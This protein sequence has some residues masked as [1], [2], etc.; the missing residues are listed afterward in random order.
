MTVRIKFWALLLAPL[1]F[2]G[3]FAAV[4]LWK[5]PEI[6]IDPYMQ[7]NVRAFYFA[8][9]ILAC[10]AYAVVWAFIDAAF[11]RP[12]KALLHG[13]R[14]ISRSNPAHELMMPRNH[15]LGEVPVIVQE[16]GASLHQA[17]KEIAAATATGTREIEAQKSRLEV[18]LRE[19]SEGVLVCD[20]DARV[21]LCNPAARRLLPTPEALGLGRSIYGLLTRQ[22]IEH[23]LDW[24]GFRQQQAGDGAPPATDAEFLCSAA[25]ESRL[26]QCRMSLLPSSGA[27]R[28]SFVLTLRDIT[29]QVAPGTLGPTG[30]KGLVEDLRRQLA[31]LR[32]AAESLSLYA[33]M[34]PGQ[35]RAF[36]RVIFDESAAL[37]ERVEFLARHVRLT[38][39]AQ[40]PSADVL[41]TDVIGAALSRLER[42]RGRMSVIVQSGDPLWLHCDG[43]SVMQL[44]EFVLT[45]LA[46][47]EPAASFEIECLLGNR[48]V[49]VDIVW[50]GRPLPARLIQDWLERPL[51]HVAGAA[52]VGE[53][54]RRHH[55][56]LWSQPHRKPGLAVLRIPLPSSPRQWSDED[57]ALPERPEF[58][59]FDLELRPAQ[60]GALADRPLKSLDYVVFDTETTGLSPSRGDEMIQIAGLRVVQGRIREGETFDRLINPGKPIPKA[61]IKFHGI[62]DAMVR[63][64]PGAA[65]IVPQFRAFVGEPDTVLVAHNAAFDM[66][67]LE[68]KEAVTGVSFRQQP[69]LDT[70]LLSGAIHD[71]TDDHTLDAIAERLGVDVHNRHTAL[72]DTLVTAQVFVKLL[73]LLEAQGI[74]TL[75]QALAL[76]EQMT[77]VRRQQAK[78]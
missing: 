32:F 18:V 66:K 78:F 54:L 34:E 19:L 45:E 64:K 74:V 70:L 55:S 60:F 7:E 51:Q 25:D 22:P 46:N 50:A 12:L 43:Q 21:L 8:G 4:S 2:T 14:I 11:V 39:A 1:A 52:T 13:A 17:R 48:Q 65:V 15:L 3:L 41:S 16:L 20:A 47:Q 56:D 10:L 67:F 38:F 57:G 36:E 42:S 31:S 61:S 26:F 27:A 76:S 59:D 23:T 49:Y 37:T 71:Y 75:G 77:A 30:F 63:D 35:R 9:G 5:L 28:R 44:L 62:T 24:L 69:V 33:D 53:I 58:Y 6:V 40:W 73:D 29:S 68:L 72:G